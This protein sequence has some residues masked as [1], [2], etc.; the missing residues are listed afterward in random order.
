MGP[1]MTPLK[2]MLDTNVW[3]DYFLAR[4]PGHRAAS[5]L[6]ELAEDSE[7]IALYTSSLS[8]KDLA[9]LLERDMKAGARE[10]GVAV[11]ERVSAAARE[12]AWGCVRLVLEQSLIVP[13]GHPEVLQAFTL[14]S[15]HDDLEDDL[16][17]GS[18]YRADVDCVV[19]YDA[20]LARRSPVRCVSVHEALEI[21]RRAV[22]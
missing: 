2:L 13:V 4:T 8:I 16:L 17:L 7:R 10:A 19:T 15:V 9:Y 6:L 11:T 3:L 14:K 5:E 18:A 1:V 12:T 20:A 22:S 21:A